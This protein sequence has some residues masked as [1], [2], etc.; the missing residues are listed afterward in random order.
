MSVFRKVV[1]FE[2][3]EQIANAIVNKIFEICGNIMLRKRSQLEPLLMKKMNLYHKDNV[4]HFKI[5]GT[6]SEIPT[7]IIQH[8][9]QCTIGGNYLYTK[10][11]FVDGDTMS[12]EDV[13]ITFI[14]NQA[15]LYCLMTS[16]DTPFICNHHKFLIDKFDDVFTSP[17]DTNGM[18]FRNKIKSIFGVVDDVELV[19]DLEQRQSS[20]DDL[21]VNDF[22]W[23]TDPDNVNIFP[24]SIK[25]ISIISDHLVSVGID[26]FTNCRS[27]ES[28][29]I[30][31]NVTSI[32]ENFLRG[33]TSIKNV[34]IPNNVTS[35][36]SYFLNGCKIIT[37][38]LTIPNSFKS[39]ENW[40]LAGCFGVT[41]V[42]RLSVI[43]S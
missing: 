28:V 41:A 25:Q 29:T 20:P 24:K 27:L 14:R 4:D 2:E 16:S 39:I 33:C 7:Q 32:G 43:T 15:S 10:K 37:T 18:Q 35:I 22:H 8:V 9:I 40:F 13:V 3:I 1:R 5:Y 38:T 34:I 42:L 21:N 6:C 23:E 17:H 26:F 36:G 11:S 30:S 12:K 19:I 31:N